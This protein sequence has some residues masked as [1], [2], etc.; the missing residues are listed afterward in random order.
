LNNPLE[1]ILTYAKLLKKKLTVGML[2][3]AQASEIQSE[4]SLIAEE[5]ARCG[6]IV[7]N[8]LLFS[9][10]RAGEPRDENLHVVIKRSLQLIDHH[11]KMHK[12]ALLE[13]TGS[14]PVVIECIPQEIEQAL[15]ALEINSIEAMPEGGTLTVG[16]RADADGQ[17]ARVF[18]KDTGVGIAT[19]DLA[20]VFEPFYTT[21]KD[22]KGT[23]LGLSVVFGIVKRHG[24]S[25][26]V[27]STV[28]LGTTVTIT[29][30]RH[31]PPIPPPGVSPHM[32]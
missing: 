30:P 10:Q 2:S 14:E 12:I 8:L 4:L 27:E 23:G 28:G 1:G 16:L 22:G 13:D 18:V 6:N 24:G 31:L 21:K 25:V 15:L 9:R 5:T 20:H 26:D 32:L 11:L 3:E 29:L 17:S 19:E 7:K